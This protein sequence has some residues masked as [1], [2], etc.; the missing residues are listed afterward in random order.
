MNHL[1]S[2]Y[3]ESTER[4]WA[5]AISAV[6]FT[7]ITT[8]IIFSQ[9]SPETTTTAKEKG[10]ITTKKVVSD[11]VPEENTQKKQLVVSHKEKITNP[12]RPAQQ[13]SSK[14]AHKIQKNTSPPLS[15]GYFIQVGAFEKKSYAHQL[16]K[17]LNHKHWPSLV[18]RK[19]VLYAVQ[20][21]PYKSKKTATHYKNKLFQQEKL[22]GFIIH[23]SF[24]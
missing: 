2:W 23:R 1:R 19:K 7:L 14:V 17:R 9:W 16:S 3:T 22:N 11:Q 18:Q 6:A 13:S 10:H 4:T 15:K 24:P 5:I 8:L 20:I 21:G 12:P